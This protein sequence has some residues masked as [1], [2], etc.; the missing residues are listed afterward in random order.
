MDI[1]KI[2]ELSRQLRGVATIKVA[3]E[4]LGCPPSPSVLAKRLQQEHPNNP[5]GK[6]SQMERLAAGATIRKEVLR[7]LFR[8]APELRDLYENPLWFTI[9]NLST[10]R[11]CDELL[12]TVTI[13]GKRLDTQTRHLRELLLDRVDVSCLPIN[14]ALLFSG[15]YSYDA[16]RMLLAKNFTIM[17]AWYSLQYPIGYIREQFYKRLSFCLGEV[18]KCQPRNWERWQLILEDCSAQLEDIG[19]WGWLDGRAGC[20][21][22]LVWN[23]SDKERSFLDE[24]L[25]V[26]MDEWPVAMPASIEQRWQNKWALWTD[27]PV[28]FNGKECPLPDVGKSS[29]LLSADMLSQ[30]TV[31]SRADPA[32]EF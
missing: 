24:C 11:V 30:L 26:S 16:Y 12:D 1:Q 17:Y 8:I 9:S 3:A 22:M 32:D 25:E 23:L 2:D 28:T 19:C 4:S 21:A 18:A 14:L 6:R 7:D 13:A 15:H 10:P 31:I 20:L 5:C 29:G 27:N